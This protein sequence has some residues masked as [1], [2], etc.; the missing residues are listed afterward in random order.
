MRSLPARKNADKFNGKP[1]YKIDQPVFMG[2]NIHWMWVIFFK[3]KN[4]YGWSIIFSPAKT[5]NETTMI[6]TSW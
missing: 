6:T 3:F 4:R 5:K 2:T 1:F